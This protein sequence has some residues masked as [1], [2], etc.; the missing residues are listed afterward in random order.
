MKPKLLVIELWQM[1][2]LLIATP[3]LRAACEKFSVTLVCKPSWQDLRPRFWPEVTVIP[4]LAPWTAFKRKYHIYAWPWKRLYRLRNEIGRGQFD[5]GLSAHAGGDPRDHA[6]LA[7]ARAKKRLGFP[8]MRSQ[9]F[10]THPL[11]RP[12][13]TA[14]VYEYWN[15]L[16][17][18]LD[19]NM[20]PR[21]KIPVPPAIRNQDTVL[22]H[23]GA[24]QPVRVWPLGRYQNL[25]NHLRKKN[26]R[27]QIACD[28]DQREWWLSAGEKNV[29]VPQ[30]VKELIRTV[31]GAAAFIGNDSGPGHLAAMAGVPTFTLFGP[32]VPEWFVPL[33]PHAEWMEGKPC[34]YKPCSDYCFFPSPH[35]LM[36][37]TEPEVWARVERFVARAATGGNG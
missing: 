30:T 28:P 32:Q 24:R 9:I 25:A 34:P 22:I 16:G 18:A 13:P 12:D 6:L 31:D 10:L 29:I 1:G 5:V 37:I 17:R 2:D 35:C 36:T 7:I 15:I 26:Y 8:R 19:L 23:S 11:Q 21:E 33:H 14:H 4:F 3:F 20:P 27:V